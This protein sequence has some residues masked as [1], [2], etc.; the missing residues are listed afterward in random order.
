MSYARTEGSDNVT[1]QFVANNPDRKRG[2]RNH[3]EEMGMGKLVI[4][5]HGAC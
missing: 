3:T 1:Q 2:D 5:E 4:R